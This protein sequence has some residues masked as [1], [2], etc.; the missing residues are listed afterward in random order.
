[1]AAPAKRNFDELIHHPDY[2]VKVQAERRETELD[3]AGIG[4]RES[5]SGRTV[6]I[7]D[8]LEEDDSIKNGAGRRGYLPSLP[9]RL[10]FVFGPPVD[11]RSA[12]APLPKFLEPLRRQKCHFRRKP[13]VISD[14]G[15]QPLAEANDARLR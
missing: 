14:I 8:P 1:M 11:L 12:V 15:R 4:K 9:M 7:G 5:R 10:H 3:A 6:G 13:T 2:D